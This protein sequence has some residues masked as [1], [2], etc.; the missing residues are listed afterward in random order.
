V[1]VKVMLVVAAPG[2]PSDAAGIQFH[3]YEVAEIVPEFALS[4]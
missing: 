3:E 4:V 1:A 2:L